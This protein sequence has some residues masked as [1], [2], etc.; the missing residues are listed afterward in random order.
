MGC[1]GDGLGTQEKTSPKTLQNQKEG[2]RAR[3]E[4]TRPGEKGYAHFLQGRQS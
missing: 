2:E 4:A 3:P 1:A